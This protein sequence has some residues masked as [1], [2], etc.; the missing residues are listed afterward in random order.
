M[1]SPRLLPR[2]QRGFS[3]IELMVG[4]T[5]GLIASI[6]IIQVM[7]LF[8]QQRRSTT[9]SADAQTNGGIALYQIAREL[10]MAGYPLNPTTDSPLECTTVTSSVA[11]ITTL[12]PVSLVNGT[13]GT[14]PASDSITI[15]YGSGQT[16]LGTPSAITTM[17]G[18]AATVG[19]SLGCRNGD[20]V[21]VI[22]GSSCAVTKVDTSVA[23][24]TTTSVPLASPQPA[25][26]A[27]GANLACIGTT[28]NEVTYAVNGATGNLERTAN[29]NGVAGTA[30]PMVTGVAMLQA[31]YGISAATNSN[32]VAQWVSAT[33]GTWT[34][35]T[36]PNRN[37]IKAIRL[38]VV[39][40]NPK[41]ETEVVSTACS[42]TTAASPS[43]VCAWEGSA[44]S[45]APTVD[46]STGNANWD[47]YR[48]R[49]FQSIVPLRNVLWSKDTL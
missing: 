48:Y 19:S 43:G 12:T 36:V 5:I 16:G 21:V 46:L 15:R 2:L 32:Q 22:S 37:L 6:V 30:T 23:A 17:V 1:A 11:G 18:G 44:T 33:G 26:A 4:M 25:I 28:W 47:K 31:Q 7:T 24:L 40:R 8:D 35:P 13:A 38:A 39:A 3:L 49:V 20:I 14:Y 45:P 27:P 34:T 42:S 29:V 9:G 41:M 10:Q